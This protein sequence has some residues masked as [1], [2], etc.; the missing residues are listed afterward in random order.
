MLQLA[1]QSGPTILV[2]VTNT[3]PAVAN[4]IVYVG[5]GHHSVFAL[6]AMTGVKI[7]NYPQSTG[8]GSSPAVAGGIVYLALNSG[9]ICALN[10]SSG[11]SLWNYA[12][13][14]DY[15]CSSPAIANGVL[16]IK[17]VNGYL[18]A[19]GKAVESSISLQP[20]LGLAGTIVTISGSGFSAGATLTA[21]VAGT[22][23][24]LNNPVVDSLGHIS[25]TF[26]TSSFTPEKYQII[27]IDSMGNSA[28]ANFTVAAVASTSWPM[29]MHDLQHSGSPDN[30]ATI[31]NNLLWKFEVDKGDGMNI[32][33]SNAGVV[34]GIVYDASQNT[35][36]YALDAYAGTCY[37]RLGLGGISVLSSPGV[38]DGVVYIG[39]GNGVYAINA[40]TG[41][42]IWSAS[43]A[44]DVLSVPAVSKGM[45]YV[46]SFDHS[47]YALRASD[48]QLVWKYTTGDYANSSPAVVDNVVYIGSSDG[49]IYALNAATGVLIWKFDSAAT[50]PY[51]D[52]SSSPAVVNGVVYIASQDGNVFAQDASNGNK[53]WNHTT[54]SLSS[55]KSSPLVAN[56]VLYI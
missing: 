10:A 38:V 7:W 30:I 1:H 19:F 28:S 2:I 12:I 20:K 46:G 42:K 11:I 55:F 51:N 48:G 23:I 52:I 18:Y 40:Y 47:V 29:F 45:V 3:S 4:G 25:T 49:Y 56:G 9:N 32:V 16:Y 53:I 35:Y 6:D 22:P 13:G 54:A 36:V 17:S 26:I 14:I 31:D 34:G 27:V 39:S 8:M 50:Y 24:A 44:M 43:A 33:S 5:S 15:T 21:T 41:T 37:W